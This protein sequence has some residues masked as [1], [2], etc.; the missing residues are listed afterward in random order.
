[1]NAA[2][3]AVSASGKEGHVLLGRVVVDA[4]SARAE[5]A[6]TQDALLEDGWFVLTAADLRRPISFRLHGYEPAVMR[7][8]GWRNVPLQNVGEVHLKPVPVALQGKLRGK[9]AL[10]DPSLGQAKVALFLQGGSVNTSDGRRDAGEKQVAT[11]ALPSGGEL[12]IGGFSPVAYRLVIS[13]PGHETLSL[14]RTFERGGTVDLGEVKLAKLKQVE[15]R[16]PSGTIS[17]RA[18]DAIALEGGTIHLR[19]RDGRLWFSEPSPAA[20]ISE[21]GSRTAP[22][23]PPR[24]SSSSPDANTGFSSPGE[25][26]RACTSTFAEDDA[27]RAALRWR[28]AAPRCCIETS[29]TATRR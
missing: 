23:A 14:D 6:L 2:V 12:S 28:N 16:T 21:S 1:M 9:V 24:T 22:L 11:S 26:R 5:D 20:S 15:L 3:A 13:A 17:A 27:R 18:G 7:P 10:E 8:T 25:P 19:Q 4:G 29:R